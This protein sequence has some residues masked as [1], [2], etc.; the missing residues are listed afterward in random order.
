MGP[1]VL[2]VGTCGLAPRAA[3]SQERG[4]ALQS[5]LVRVQA[6][7]RFVDRV[8]SG[9]AGRSPVVLQALFSSGPRLPVC[10]GQSDSSGIGSGARG[11]R[12][13]THTHPDPP[14]R[15]TPGEGQPRPPRTWSTLQTTS[16][17]PAWETRATLAEQSLCR[18]PRGRPPT[19]APDGL[20]AAATVDL[21]S[22]RRSQTRPVF[23]HP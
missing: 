22:R 3:G 20:A 18:W 12:P 19:P 23:L 9:H 14:P 8:S 4:A 2:G 1:L 13:S 7:L 5:A 10:Q 21:A 11:R 6:E 16:R 17:L 15:V